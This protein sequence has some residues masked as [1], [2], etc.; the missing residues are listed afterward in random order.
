VIDIDAENVG[1]P[2]G[3]IARKWRERFMALD[4]KN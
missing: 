4:R 1:L 2:L 3:R